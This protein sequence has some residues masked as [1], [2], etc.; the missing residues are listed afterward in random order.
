MN[1]RS[2]VVGRQRADLWSRTGHP[3]GCRAA[4]PRDGAVVGLP[5]VW[6]GSAGRSRVPAPS[7]GTKRGGQLGG[8]TGPDAGLASLLCGLSIA[9]LLGDIPWLDALLE[10]V[11]AWTDTGLTII[12]DPSA[13]PIALVVFRILIQW[14]SGLG[15]VMFMLLLR[16]SSP[17][18]VRQLFEA[19]GRLSGH[20]T[21]SEALA[22]RDWYGARQFCYRASGS[23][24]CGD[25]DSFG[26]WVSAWYSS[27]EMNSPPSISRSM[28]R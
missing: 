26:D 10:G 5:G 21:P 19:E 1:R 18:A 6:D 2:A 13:L 11:S 28:M 7:S 24:S 8:N 15:I 9:F 3:G 17:R 16:A 27:Q 4:I 14:F 12:Q 20:A 25:S 22:P 23:P